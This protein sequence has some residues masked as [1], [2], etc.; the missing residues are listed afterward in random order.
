[1]RQLP[2]CVAVYPRDLR[3]RRVLCRKSLSSI[4]GEYIDSL[5]ARPVFAGEKLMR[6]MHALVE[7]LPENPS[8]PIP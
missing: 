1:L 3:S 2:N 5:E 6:A 4:A 8:D 7:A